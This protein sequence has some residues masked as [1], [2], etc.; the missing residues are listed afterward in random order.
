MS[1]RLELEKSFVIEKNLEKLLN[2]IEKEGFVL[3]SFNTE[4]DT[5]FTDRALEFI[6]D[7]VCLR[8]RKTDD[9]FLELTYKPRSDSNTERYGKREVNIRIN[10]EDLEDIKYV[11]DKLGYLEY[12][13][14]KKH[15]RTYS[16]EIDGYV[17]NIMID[18]IDGVGDF[19]EFEI[20]SESTK[21]KEIVAEKL[22]NFITLFECNKF[23]EK[24]K[25]YRDIVKEYMEK[26]D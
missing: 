11:I 8:T 16:K 14:F 17:H 1:N 15:R 19:A 24:T 6:Q 9:K 25:P 5:Y 20:L 23:K 4:E 13:S 22:D 21:D 26:K 18:N 3:V 12:V 7:R 10:P 2:K